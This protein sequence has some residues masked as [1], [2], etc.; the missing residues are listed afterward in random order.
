MAKIVRKMSDPREPFCAAFLHYRC[1]ENLRPGIAAR[2]RAAAMTYFAQPPPV[3]I[4]PKLVG[5]LGV[6]ATSS[7]DLLGRWKRAPSPHTCQ[8][9]VPP[10]SQCYSDHL[11]AP[12]AVV[13]VLVQERDQG[14]SHD[15]L[16]L[17]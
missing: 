7:F 8:R 5:F 16:M 1:G 11:Q 10:T 3:E 2:R 15:A 17:R 14:T 12:L 9:P 6:D 13:R 4:A